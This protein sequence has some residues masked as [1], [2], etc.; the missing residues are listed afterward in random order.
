MEIYVNGQKWIMPGYIQLDNQID[1]AFQKLYSSFF[2]NPFY[3]FLDLSSNYLSAFEEFAFQYLDRVI[4]DYTHQDQFFTNFTS[5]WRKYMD[6]G[7]FQEAQNFWQRI[8]EIANKWEE[9]RSLRTHKGSPYYFWAVTAILQ[10]EVDKGFFL[11]HMAY[12]EDTLTQSTEFPPSPAF[13]FVTL[14]FEKTKQFFYSYVK[15]LADD[16]DQFINKYRKVSSTVLDLQEFRNLFLIQPP[17]KHAIFSLTFILAKVNI[18]N[19]MPF[20][21]F[22][23]EFAGQYILNMLF[24]LALVI[25][26]AISRKNTNPSQWRFIDLAEFLSISSNFFI[27]KSNLIFVN[28][29]IDRNLDQTLLSLLDGNFTFDDG[30]PRSRLECDIAIAYCIRNYAAHN[31]SSYPIFWIRRDNLVQSLFNVLFLCVDILYR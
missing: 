24:D 16:L 30:K 1:T 15:Q 26:E 21:A 25:D 27:R 17:S 9:S 13:W 3:N 4:N 22:Q 5:I 20:F 28:Q 8:L 31:I 2:N 14:D 23:S 11:M 29:E 6:S 19:F 10:G 7:R 12:Q 18:L